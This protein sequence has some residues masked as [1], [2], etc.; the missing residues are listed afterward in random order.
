MAHVFISYCRENE[1]IVKALADDVG[2]SGHTV[3]LDQQLA[4]GHAWWEQI[5]A[6]IREADVFVFALAPQSL[7]SEACKREYKYAAA[8]ARPVLPVLVA[9]GV[10]INL[11]PAELSRLQHVD[12][13]RQDK[14]AAIG[15]LR[16]LAGLPQAPPLPEPLPEPPPPPL[17][18][19]GGL[20]EQIDASGELTFAQQAALVLKLKEAA[21]APRDRDEVRTLLSRLRGRHDLYA[22]IADEIDALLAKATATAAPRAP[23]A[24]GAPFIPAGASGFAGGGTPRQSTE[25]GPS[26]SAPPVGHSKFRSAIKLVFVVF[27]GFLLAGVTTGALV[28]MGVVSRYDTDGSIAVLWPAWAAI[29]WFLLPAVVRRLRGQSRSGRT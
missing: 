16:A 17:S 22:R 28:E 13:R 11:L 6:R 8:L 21:G 4:G 29:L 19:L 23:A 25:S 26:A 3:W 2:E 14:R 15:L 7:E 1:H 20:M 18:Y 9:E 12:Y 24:N 27:G 5:L 10:S